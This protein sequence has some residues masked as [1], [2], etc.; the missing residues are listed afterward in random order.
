MVT[1]RT[2]R[3][4]AGVLLVLVLLV[5]AGTVLA[6]RAARP[7]RPS[8]PYP[9][10]QSLGHVRGNCSGGNE[11]V[12]CDSR[13]GPR[14]FLDVRAG[15]DVRA[16]SEALFAALAARGWKE[17]ADGRVATDF[18]EGGQPED[19]QPV[20]CRPARGCVGLFR[21]EAAGYVLA[22]WQAPPGDG[23]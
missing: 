23:A 21:F 13:D 2:A 19:I 18:S 10:G 6:L 8:L 4:A 20:Y 1:G 15:G 14:S 16:A 3:R 17:D 12:G 7:P 22:W 5:A 11:V 9:R